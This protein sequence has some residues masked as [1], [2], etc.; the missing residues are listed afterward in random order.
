MY[1]TLNI[2]FNI[3]TTLI[4]TYLI[5]KPLFFFQET[6][7][8]SPRGIENILFIGSMIFPLFHF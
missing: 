5:L 1:I 2:F 7:S 4:I 8:L 6:V 3:K